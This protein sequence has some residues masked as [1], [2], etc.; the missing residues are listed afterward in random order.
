MLTALPAAPV[1]AARAP[2]V[3]TAAG[4]LGTGRP[5]DVALHVN[6]LAVSGSTVYGGDV[7]YGVVRAFDTA[8][9]RTWVVAGTGNGTVRGV[10]GV[11]TRVA[12]GAPSALAVAP[13][14]AL[15]VAGGGYVQRVDRTGRLT[16]LAGGGTLTGPLVEGAA[17]RG[18]L[19]QQVRGAAVAPDG[20]VYVS[21]TPGNRVLAFSPDGRT[22][23]VAGTGVAGFSPPG[24]PA[25]ALTL[26][27]PHGLALTRAGDLLVADTD[28]NRVVRIDPLGISHPFAATGPRAGTTGDGG[29]AALAELDSPTGLALTPGGDLLVS[30]RS[31][32]RRVRGDGTIAAFHRTGAFAIAVASNGDLYYSSGP[33]I[34]VRRVAGR[35]GLFAGRGVPHGV[36]RSGDPL[37]IQSY[38]PSGVA[39]HG[40]ALLWA[41]GNARAWRAQGRRAQLI[42]SNDR[43]FWDPGSPDPD[44]WQLLLSTSGIAVG[45]T[46]RVYVTDRENNKVYVLTARGRRHLAGRNHICTPADDPDDIGDGGPARDARLCEPAGIAVRG[47]VVYIA[48]RGHRRVRA[49]DPNGRI[50]TVAAG[51]AWPLDVTAGPDGALYVADTDNH[52]VRRVDRN[53]AV[54]T[55]AG[56]AGTGGYAGD[57]GAATAAR[58]NLPGAV[59]VAA[60][61]TVFVADTGNSVIRRIDR[62]GVVTTFAG[63]GRDEYSGD[64]GAARSAG[65][66]CPGDLAIDDAARKLYV[67]DTCNHRVRVVSF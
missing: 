9:R 67:A 57:G 20:T 24:V 19:L 35:T 42:T 61:G 18:V 28:N 65:F 11:A 58:L 60:D 64:G 25:R 34:E 52:V 13:S 15:V 17:A 10:D 33:D 1:T 43:P 23:V 2:V 31:A 30:T 38:R 45:S 51:L 46:G 7:L 27:R 47:G 66:G 37:R 50:R 32:V 5:I 63:N 6:A 36:V 21:D 8:G 14:G 40:G 3:R 29:P 26:D 55:I 48:D 56:T 54:R 39:V 12:T 62:K 49:I 53:G 44:G 59:A 4:S 41:D 22:R 16:V